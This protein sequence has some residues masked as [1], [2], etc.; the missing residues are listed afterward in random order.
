[1]IDPV[2][3]RSTARL[4]E[5]YDRF[6]RNVEGSPGEVSPGDQQRFEAALSRSSEPIG[7]TST[8][9]VGATR[10]AQMQVADPWVVA[11]PGR[12]GVAGPAAPTMGERILDGVNNLR[13]SWHALDQQTQKLVSNPD[14]SIVDLLNF[15]VQAQQTSL[16]IQITS[17]EVGTIT[18]KV[19]G[20]LKTG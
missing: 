4:Q 15:Q 7:H 16:V 19:D 1:M 11:P 17:T 9:D 12:S 13:D 20:L 8:A 3:G 6:A 10:V 5:L 18:Q 14:F 2:S